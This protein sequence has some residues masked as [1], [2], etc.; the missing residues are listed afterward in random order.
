TSRKITAEELEQA[1]QDLTL[2]YVNR[3]Y[4]NSGAVIPGQAFGTGVIKV[5]IIEGRLTGIHLTGNHWFRRWWIRNE[6]RRSAGRPLNFNKLKEGL[7]LLRQNPTISRVNAELRPGGVPGESIL[8]LDI[9]DTQP[10]RFALEFSNKR[11]P[12]DGAEILEAQ[13][14]DL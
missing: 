6:V 12:S 14:A 11:P 2:F 1:R 10:F 9:K 8:D 7:Q 13:L 3:G 4:I 5:R